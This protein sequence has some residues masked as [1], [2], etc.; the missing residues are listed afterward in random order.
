[1]YLLFVDESGTHGGLHPF[2]LGALAIHENDA[3]RMQSDL[4][5][6]V[7]KHLGRVPLNIEEFELHAGE[8]RNAK[9]PLGSARQ[10]SIWANYPRSLRLALLEEAYDLVTAFRP[11]NAGLPHALFGV[12][13]DRQFHGDWT[14]LERERYAYEVLLNKFDVMLK[15][16]R[17]QRGLPNRGLVI[18]DRR[19]VAERDIQQWTSEWRVAAGNIGQLRNLADVPLFADSRASRLLQVADLISYALFR[20]YS[21]DALDRR[22]IDRIW[23]RFDSEKGVV[24]GCVHYTPSYGRGSCD[25]AACQDR[26]VAEAQR[27]I[28]LP[29]S[30]IRRRRR[31]RTSSGIELGEQ[32]A[33]SP[34]D[35]GE[36]SGGSASAERSG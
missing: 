5:K 6:L 1:M 13:V 12:V 31:T 33:S 36:D 3:A 19:V 32:A 9:K 25:C 21:P 22:Y 15:R 17:V 24:Y 7:V 28:V 26:L 29:R 30:V 2:V 35:G 20:R 18:H 4:D 8:M 23:A 16:C 14:D 11:E 27:R 10:T 34:D